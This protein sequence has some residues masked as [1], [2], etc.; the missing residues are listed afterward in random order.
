M[1]IRGRNGN[2]ESVVDALIENNLISAVE[3]ANHTHGCDLGAE[4]LLLAPGFIDLQSN[5]YDGVDFNDPQ[6]SVAQIAE[7]TRRLW[8]T[9]VT[10]FCPTVITASA[11]HIA[12]CLS[13][14]ARAA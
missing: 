13:N 12:Q 9:G 8:R 7:A 2:D 4:D 14:L 5:G 11:A 3:R 6:T 10:S 1:R